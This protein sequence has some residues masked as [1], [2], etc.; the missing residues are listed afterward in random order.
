MVHSTV[1]A[2]VPPHLKEKLRRHR[3]KPSEVI[4][5][6]LEEEVRRK[7]VEEIEDAHRRAVEFTK[8][9]ITARQLMRFIR[10]T[11]EER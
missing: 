3:I 7:E 4:R 5:R 11:R 1:A 2:R 8:G 9:R 10:E 6:A